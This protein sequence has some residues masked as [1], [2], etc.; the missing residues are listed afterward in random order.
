MDFSTQDDFD[1]HADD[2]ASMANFTP[3]ETMF[4]LASQHLNHQD[5]VPSQ[6]HSVYNMAPHQAH[7]YQPHGISAQHMTAEQLT[8][9][10][11]SPGHQTLS[12][13]S[14]RQQ[15]RDSSQSDPTSTQQ[16]PPAPQAGGPSPQ[17]DITETFYGFV[18]NTKDALHLIEACLRGK[19][20]HVARRP[21]DKERE[22]LIRS[23][24][25]FVYEEHSAGIKRW[26]DGMNWSPS[27]ILQNFLVYR[28]LDKPFPPGEKKKAKKTTKKN[29]AA[30]QHGALMDE[31]RNLMTPT[32][33]SGASTEVLREYVGSLV[34]SY[35]FKPRGLV[36]KTISVQFNGV[37]HHLVSY[38]SLDDVLK[39]NLK[40]VVDDPKI[41]E[42]YPR[43]ELIDGQNYRNPVGDELNEGFTFPSLTNMPRMVLHM[44][45]SQMPN[46]QMP[47]SYNG[48]TGSYLPSPP[49]FIPGYHN[50]MDM[51]ST[52]HQLAM[53]SPAH[54]TGQLL[55]QEMG[56]PGTAVYA[57]N[58][59]SSQ[60]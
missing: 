17:P 36:K 11:P 47:I 29:S 50:E 27:R 43:P 51:H 30:G 5:M 40:R 12:S 37:H 56:Y 48:P 46:S 15:R 8:P 59:W 10:L 38:Y 21:H 1:S 2:F 49:H 28:E 34:D 26:T 19:L 7:L 35:D 58:G 53:V 14:Q 6:E 52:Q 44:P 22:F 41:L 13:Q 4:G 20:H 32:D 25:I 39:G 45:G 9:Q 33:D 23:G 55:G 16:S 3:L 57:D 24:S 60:Y 54:N 42:C 18:K 31:V